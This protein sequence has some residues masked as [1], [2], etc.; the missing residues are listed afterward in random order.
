MEQSFEHSFRNRFC[1]KEM[2]SVAVP[3]LQLA[4]TTIRI[5]TDSQFYWTA[6]MDA[7]DVKKVLHAAI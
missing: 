6:R 2:Q 7:D 5:F 3:G 1:V 4:N